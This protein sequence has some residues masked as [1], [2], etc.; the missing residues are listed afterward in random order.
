MQRQLFVVRGN[1]I[2]LGALDKTIQTVNKRGIL[3]NAL[4]MS[5]KVLYQDNNKAS[6]VWQLDDSAFVFYR[7]RKTDR[8]GTKLLYLAAKSCG[9]VAKKPPQRYYFLLFCYS[10]NTLKHGLH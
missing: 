9:F 4:N 6:K 5:F 10:W 2:I 1:V 7:R 3:L 8:C